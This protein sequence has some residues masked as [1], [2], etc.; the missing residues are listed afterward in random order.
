MC[1]PIIIIIIIIII[2]FPQKSSI[3]RKLN[4]LRHATE[5]PGSYERWKLRWKE[6]KDIKTWILFG[7]K[8]KIQNTKYAIKTGTKSITTLLIQTACKF[9][10]DTFDWTLECS[11][12]WEIY[13]IDTQNIWHDPPSCGSGGPAPQYDLWLKLTHV[14][15]NITARPVQ[16]G[17]YAMTQLRWS[18]LMFTARVHRPWRHSIESYGNIYHRSAASSVFPEHRPVGNTFRASRLVRSRLYSNPHYRYRSLTQLARP[19][20]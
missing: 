10:I 7:L 11:Q 5:Q 12:R 1:E 9:K 14:F 17:C 13:S 15:T 16:Y 19:P 4:V 8:Y 20:P 18:L 3:G 6:K 2:C